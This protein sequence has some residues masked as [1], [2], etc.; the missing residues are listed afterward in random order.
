MRSSTVGL[1]GENPG[2][3]LY[4][5]K[6]NMF[7]PVKKIL[8]LDDDEF[9]T[10]SLKMLLEN[11]KF[12]CSTAHNV[13]EAY[14]IL[15]TDTPDLIISD[16]RM[17]DT[18]GFEFRK[19]LLKRKRFDKIPFVFLSSHKSE[20]VIIDSYNYGIKDYISKS[21]KPALQ[22][23]KLKNIISS[24]NSERSNSIE[25]IKNETR[26]AAE[27]LSPEIP[28]RYSSFEL[29]YVNKPY[30]GIAGGDFI[31]SIKSPG[32][33]TLVFGDVMGKRYDAWFLTFSYI[34]Y[35]RSIIRSLASSSS[36][37]TPSAILKLLNE[38]IYSDPRLSDIFSSV[39]II[40]LVEGTGE[41]VYS[42]AGD[43]PLLL[44]NRRTQK[45]TKI[46]SSGLLLGIR[47]E[48]RYADMKLNLKNHEEVLLYTDG[49][50]E[51][52]NEK[53]MYGIERL[54]E[55]MVNSGRNTMI[56]DLMGSLEKFTGGTY[57]DDI[58]ILNI[59]PGKK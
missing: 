33:L 56:E 17:P 19:N 25:R 16:I 9:T 37:I 47:P 29:G 8:V 24:I 6:K 1:P 23:T 46:P 12:H 52:V 32:K 54:M 34:S 27:S 13:K 18:D 22:I 26:D 7:E 2:L 21:Y 57:Y 36:D 14:K 31:D 20:K 5:K 11:E 50:I 39:S 3:N 10:N 28:Q 38:S 30:N 44:L 53:E 58:S 41:L 35:I 15:R 42:G 48:N 45:V 4:Q 51:A 49:I 55:Q 59:K 40:Q 43:L